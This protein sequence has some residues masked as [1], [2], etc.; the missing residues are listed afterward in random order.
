M[1]DTEPKYGFRYDPMEWVKNDE[2]LQGAQ[3]RSVVLGSPKPGDMDVL[4]EQTDTVLA[5]QKEDGS[6]GEN[7]GEALVALSRLGC[8]PHR[9][10]IERAVRYL[11]REELEK[12]GT[13]DYDRLYAACLAGGHNE[14]VVEVLRASLNKL[15]DECADGGKQGCPYSSFR[16]LLALWAGR[17]FAEVVPVLDDNLSWIVEGLNEIGLHSNKYPWVFL[18]LAGE[19]D[20]PL[21]RQALVRQVALLLRTQLPDGSWGD[22][23]GHPILP[24]ATFMAIRALARHGLLEPLRHRPPLPPDWKIVKTESED[25]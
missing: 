6:I 18:E 14:Q 8:S 7:T 23:P 19:V 11:L 13:L 15:L 20:R 24:P 25:S 17:K 5:G 9:P 1:S 3:V 10:E 21:C 4:N 16:P 22:W 2:S 12:D